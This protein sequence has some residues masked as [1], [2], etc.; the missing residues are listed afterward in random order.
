MAT[1]RVAFRHNKDTG[2]LTHSIG[3]EEK[4]F[5]V[6]YFE[7]LSFYYGADAFRKKYPSGIVQ[8]KFELYKIQ[9]NLC[10][11]TRL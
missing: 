6:A 11:V 8:P 4:A 10:I 9:D 1:E 2:E 5:N 3:G 7:E